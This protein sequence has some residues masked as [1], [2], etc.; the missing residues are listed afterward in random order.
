MTDTDFAIRYRP[1]K[2]ADEKTVPRRAALLPFEEILPWRKPKPYRG[3]RNAH[4]YV[5]P[6][7]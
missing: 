2:G 3:Q 6:S 1:S 5:S 4:A 7:T